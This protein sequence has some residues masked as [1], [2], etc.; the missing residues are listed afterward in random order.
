MKGT[1]QAVAHGAISILNAMSTGKGGAIGINL[2]T[3]S[4]VTL[5]Q[6][7]GDFSGIIASDPRES[8]KLIISVAE[9]TLEYY[10]YQGKTSAEI[11]TTSN[12]PIAVG[13]KSSSAAANAT[14][15]ATVAALG[16]EA[17]ADALVR[18]GIEASLESGV[19]FT[20]A[21][22]DSF[23]SYHGGGVITDNLHQKVEKLVNVPEAIRFFI[24]VPPRKIYTSKLDPSVFA[25]IRGIVDLAYR[26]ASNGKLWDAL[27]LNGMAYSSLLGEDQRASFAAIAAGALGA[28]LTGK[29]PAVVAV[30]EE[31]EAD[32]VRHAL[33]KF[34]GTVLEA[35]PNRSEA[36]IES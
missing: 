36:R 32:R 19:S 30:T 34:D 16:E 1:G 12:I 15:L 22:D 10:G 14:A 23:A 6:K 24:L 2:W 35:A 11:I 31:E 27:T 17:D 25:P 3:R 7:P 20:G 21:F 33:A 29:G 13:L 26:Q 18:I 28:G 9:K 5:S 4:K 8:N